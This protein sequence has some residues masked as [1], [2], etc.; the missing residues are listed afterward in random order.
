MRTR[1]YRSRT[2]T[3][4]GGVCGGLARYLGIDTTV[5]RLFFI[6]FALLDGPAVPLYIVLWI[7][8]PLEGD[9]PSSGTMRAGF[10]EMASQVRAVGRGV[11][12][13]TA[14]EQSRPS[15]LIGAILL[16]AGALF[17]FRNLNFGWMSWMHN[18]V[19]WPVVLIVG[20]GVLLLRQLSTQPTATSNVPAEYP[21]S[22]SVTALLP[23][24]EPAAV[25]M[26]PTDI[27]PATYEKSSDAASTSTAPM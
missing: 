9:V 5:V 4:I 16:A 1:L 23:T 19:L 26:P 10:R 7:L 11:G 20:G 18:D 15:A 8:I 22:T 2:D 6:L 13:A 24:E 21:P 12:G 17:L 14:R 27:Q 3:M 25:A